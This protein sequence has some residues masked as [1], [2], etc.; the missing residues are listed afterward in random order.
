ME[1]FI[2]SWGYLAVFVLTVAES[3]CVPIPSELTLGIGGALASGATL[4]GAVN[5]HP[6]NLALIIVMGVLGSVAGSFVAYA[7]GRTGGRAFLDRFGKFL[8]L[9]HKD[10][11]R[12]EAWFARRGDSAV[13]IGRVVPVV[14]T[15]ISLPAGLAEMPLGRFGIYTT[16]GVTVWV[17]VLS[18]IGYGLGGSYHS[19]VM[20]LGDASYV[21]AGLAVVALAV[22]L[23][24]RVRLVRAERA[25]PS[26]AGGQ[27][28]RAEKRDDDRR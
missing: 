12:A 3:A 27:A 7:V 15:F 23:I 19:M 18:G 8:L 2:S 14:R 10:L 22:G 28:A 24:H 6:L 25:L 9:T 20:A 21:V 4:S 13:L 1:H 17:T 11:D 5:H 16:I 26:A